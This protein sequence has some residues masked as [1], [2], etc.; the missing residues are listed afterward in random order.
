[1][2]YRPNHHVRASRTA[3]ALRRILRRIGAG[4]GG[5]SSS[6]THLRMGTFNE[7]CR[8]RLPSP[9]STSPRS[10]TARRRATRSATRSTSRGTPSGSATAATGSPSTTTCR[11][12]PAP[13]PR[14]SIGHLAAGTSTIRVGAG[15]IMLPN[16]SP[17]VIAEQ[18]G[19]LESLYPGPHRP[20]PRPGAGHRP[21]H[22]PRA[23]P[24]PDERATS[25]PQDVL[26]LQALL[27]RRRSRARR[28]RPS[29]ARARACRSGSSA[30][31][32]S[33][34]SSRRC[35]ACPTPSPRTSRPTT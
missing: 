21:A 22:R 6:N 14:S 26:E 33:A 15:G 30:R 32:S 19:T 4:F 1:M 8:R 5:I 17:L 16:H 31:A 34:R 3:L 10:P 35:S 9:S 18:F 28:C 13:R 24:R 20:R 12:S 29:P 25:F 7:A 11:A 23:A 2:S 27:R